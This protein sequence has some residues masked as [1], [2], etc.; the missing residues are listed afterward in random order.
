MKVITNDKQI[1]LEVLSAQDLFND[2]DIKE[3][4]IKGI[5]SVKHGLNNYDAMVNINGIDI[6]LY[7]DQNFTN[8]S[9]KKIAAT[10][11][12]LSIE[13]VIEK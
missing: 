8:V 9:I 5:G 6:I 12:L 4:K 11:D 3:I 2:T 10:N 1:A 7:R 13:F